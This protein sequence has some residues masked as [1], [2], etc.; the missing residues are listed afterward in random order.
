MAVFLS[1]GTPESAPRRDNAA[2]IPVYLFW[3]VSAVTLAKVQMVP[4]SALQ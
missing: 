4:R 1:K 2:S 3:A